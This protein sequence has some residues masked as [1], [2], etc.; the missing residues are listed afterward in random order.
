MVATGA[1]LVGANHSLIGFGLFAVD[2]HSVSGASVSMI[3]G[4][5]SNR[6]CRLACMSGSRLN[7]VSSWLLRVPIRGSPRSIEGATAS[8][9]ARVTVVDET[10]ASTCPGAGATTGAL[11]VAD[12]WWDRW[13]EAGAC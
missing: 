10:R 8:P 7:A 2:G 4:C 5:P 13:S 11:A 6:T 1:S 12:A 3:D 9:G